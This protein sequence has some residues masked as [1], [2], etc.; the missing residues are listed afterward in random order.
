M[1]SLKEKQ[2]V[3]LFCH[4]NTGGFILYHLKRRKPDTSRYPWTQE[5]FPANVG[6]WEKQPFNQ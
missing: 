6:N 2:A 3:Q 1:H 5:A 4:V